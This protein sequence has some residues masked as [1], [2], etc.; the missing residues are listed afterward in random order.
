[1]PIV[2]ASQPLDLPA[3]TAIYRHHVLHGTGTFEIDPP[4]LHE[5]R[6][7]HQDVLTKGLPWLVAQADDGQVLGYAYANW[8]KPRPAFRFSA[9]DSIYVAESARGQGLG[10]L[11]LD[12]LCHDCEVA[13]V[14]KLIAVI[15]DS[16]N[17]GSIGLHQA[18]GFTPVGTLTSVGWKFGRWLDTVFMEKS[19]GAGDQTAPE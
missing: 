5:M 14:R 1:M 17:A 11:L 10:R 15:G 6:A 19:L 3:I 7:R 9:E 13:G 12:R 16:A 2:R 18:L 8:F 4:S